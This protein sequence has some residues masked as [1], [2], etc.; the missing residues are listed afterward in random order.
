M[1]HDQIPLPV[2]PDLT[3]PKIKKLIVK[4]VMNVVKSVDIHKSFPTWK[5]DL[6][7]HFKRLDLLKMNERVMMVEFRQKERESYILK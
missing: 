6:Y 1:G 4:N 5:I 3:A 2:S 7:S